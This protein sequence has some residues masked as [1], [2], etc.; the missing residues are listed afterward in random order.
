MGSSQSYISSEVAFTAVVLVGAIGLGYHQI[1]QNPKQKGSASSAGTASAATKKGKKKKAKQS[2]TLSDSTTPSATVTSKAAEAH[3]VPFPEVIPGQF[4]A[5]ATAP[6][7][8]HDTPPTKPKKAKKKKGKAATES[9]AGGVLSSSVDYQ[10]ESSVGPSKP[11]KSKRTQSQRSQPQPPP[12]SNVTKPP[13]S[14]QQSTTSI[15]TDGSWTR[16][17][18]RRR[19]A[20]AVEGG[21]QSGPSADFTTTSDAGITT[22]VTGNSSPVAERTEDESS[23]SNTRDSGENRRTL[24]EKLLPKPRKTGVDDMLETPDYP[25]LSRVMRVQPHPD[26]KP[27]SGFSWG[28][29]ED[30][31]V[32]DGGGNDAD[33]EDDGWGVVKS[34][35]SKLDRSSPSASQVHNQKAPEALTKRQRQNANKRE[36]QKAAKAAAE[37]ERLAL[38][39]K[40]KRELERTKIAEQYASKGGG[41]SAASGGMKATVDER[42]KLVWE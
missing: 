40:H 14:L 37:A 11:S 36:E 15:D 31:R 13:K 42:G 28:D 38:L 39:A 33:K 41:K 7:P 4:D 21:G 2:D 3:V 30:V 1:S 8:G 27:A 35:R 26:E 17:E 32:G 34:K 16:V 19:G 12:S 9:S 20:S 18:P 22:S 23:Q 29:Y 10:S 5:T 25:E 24:A 6:E